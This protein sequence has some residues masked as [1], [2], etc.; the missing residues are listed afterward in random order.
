MNSHW[1]ECGFFLR[2]L[3]SFLH[4]SECLF[5]SGF[6]ILLPV[7]TEFVP[8]SIFIEE[9]DPISHSFFSLRFPDLICTGEMVKGF[10]ILIDQKLIKYIDE[11][12][13]TFIVIIIDLSSVVCRVQR[14]AED[15][16]IG[17]YSPLKIKPYRFTPTVGLIVGR[18]LA[19]RKAARRNGQSQSQS[20]RIWQPKDR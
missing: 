16:F 18:K 6:S 4:S 9:F 11:I 17:H 13:D 1:I 7:L 2:L 15:I 5:P 8:Q 10:P 19:F 12:S 20:L 3:S 14:S